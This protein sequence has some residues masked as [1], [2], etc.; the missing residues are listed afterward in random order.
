MLHPNQLNGAVRECLERC[1]A[2]RDWLASLADYG[3]RLRADG[4]PQ[5]DIEDVEMAVQQILAAV[6]DTSSM[7]SGHNQ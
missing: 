2:S 6:L 3:E 4:W 7:A 5:P 1:Y